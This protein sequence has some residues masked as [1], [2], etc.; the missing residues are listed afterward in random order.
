MSYGNLLL[1][2]VL[3]K[4]SGEICGQIARENSVVMQWTLCGQHRISAHCIIVKCLTNYLL[5]LIV[6]IICHL[7]CLC[8]D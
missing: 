5:T 7:S 1:P 6:K 8:A 2:V 3:E 4:V